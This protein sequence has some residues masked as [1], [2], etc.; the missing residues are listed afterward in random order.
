MAIGKLSAQ[1]FNHVPK[2]GVLKSNTAIRLMTGHMMQQIQI[3]TA[4]VI[5][6]GRSFGR[7][8]L[9]ASFFAIFPTIKNSRTNAAGII[10]GSSLNAETKTASVTVPV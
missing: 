7:M 10:T 2:S 5:N 6:C 8:T 9:N 4:Y 3:E 1:V